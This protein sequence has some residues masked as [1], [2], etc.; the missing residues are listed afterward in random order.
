MAWQDIVAG[1]AG[2]LAGDPSFGL[3]QMQAKMNMQNAMQKL[4]QESEEHGIEMQYRK[5]MMKKL[6]MESSKMEQEQQ[7]MWPSIPGETQFEPSVT[8]MP[9][10]TGEVPAGP[11][12]IQAQRFKGAGLE[13]RVPEAVKKKY[14]WLKE[15]EEKGGDYEVFSDPQGNQQ[16]LRKGSTIPSGWKKYEK[17]P[18]IKEPTFES[19]IEYAGATWTGGDYRTKEGRDKFFEFVKTPQGKKYLDEKVSQWSLMKQPPINVFT[20]VGSTSGQPVVFNPK[21][22][23]FTTGKF[24]EGAEGGLGPKIEPTMTY[25]ATKEMGD[26]QD[27]NKLAI[28]IKGLVEKSSKLS[29]PITGRVRGN[30]S[31]LVADPEWVRVM[32]KIGKLRPVIYA[33]SGKQINEAEQKWLSDEILPNLTKPTENFMVLL[34]DFI[35]WTQTKYNSRLGAY[36]SAGYRT[37]KFKPIEKLTKPTPT[38]KTDYKSLS[39]EELMRKLEAK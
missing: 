2:G 26:W 19:A 21:T 29:G 3:K 31:K 37:D 1:V 27:L 25:E 11:S 34:N 15:K 17:S 14:P 4:K 7:P 30:I 8:G 35:D 24:P 16:Y 10:T 18:E 20:G 33:L 12:W 28:E 23:E 9:T 5:A 6:E 36:T 22:K 32:T 39:N 38:P 13:V